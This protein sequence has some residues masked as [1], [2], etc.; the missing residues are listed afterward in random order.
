MSN[1]ERS[2]D[3]IEVALAKHSTFN[4]LKNVV[5]YNVHGWGSELYIGHECDM[6][7]LSKAGYLTEIEIKRSWTDFVADFKKD[8]SHDANLIKYFYYCVPES[9]LDRVYD[10]LEELNVEYSGVITFDEHL[11]ITLYGCR[12][13]V[14]LN[15][16]SYHIKECYPY[17]KLF[18]EEQFQIARLGAMR[19]IKLKEKTIK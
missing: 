1:T 8:H 10:K 18:L 19:S 7:V 17:R 14:H 13:Q 11:K 3:E 6:L 12:V 9:L 2:L 4:Y 16:Y 5:V 15:T